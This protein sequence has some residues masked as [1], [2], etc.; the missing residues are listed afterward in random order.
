MSS[1][2]PISWKVIVGYV[3]VT[4]ALVAVGCASNTTS[5][6][7]NPPLTDKASDSGAGASSQPAEETQKTLTF[8]GNG[9]KNLGTIRITSESVLK[10]TNDGDLMSVMTESDPFVLVN[11]QGASGDTVVNPG[12]YTDVQVNALG[13]WTIKI[14]AR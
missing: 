13:N 5:D 11:S 12:K 8:S 6:S 7:T 4:L 14:K 10:W 2:T 9:L 1:R 3:A